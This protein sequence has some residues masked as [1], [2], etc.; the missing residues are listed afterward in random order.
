MATPK[1]APTSSQRPRRAVQRPVYLDD[2]VVDYAGKPSGQVVR[3]KEKAVMTSTPIS[4]Y[5]PFGTAGSSEDFMLQI[6][7]ITKQQSETARRQTELLE[8]VLLHSTPQVSTQSSRASSRHQSPRTQILQSVEKGQPKSEVSPRDVSS[9]P[10]PWSQPAKPPTPLV[11]ELSQALSKTQ[12]RDTLFQSPPPVSRQTTLSSHQ[13]ASPYCSTKSDPARNQL[14]DKAEPWMKSLPPLP[15]QSQSQPSKQPFH[16]IPPPKVYPT[17]SQFAEAEPMPQ[18]LHPAI[19]SQPRVDAESYTPHVSSYW[20]PTVEGPTF[21]DFV[22]ED[23][24]Q[25]VELRI[26]LDNLLHPQLPEHYKYSILLKHVKVPNGHRLVLAHAES[27]TPYT[28]ALQALDR[29][30]G[31]PYQFVLR[32]IEA[33]ENL[34]PIRAGDE[35]AFDDFS[36][37]VQAIVG[38]LKALKGDGIEELHSGSNVKRLLSRLPRSQQ[39]QFRRHHL[40]RNPDKTKFSLLEFADWLQLEAN[41]MEFD[42]TD[43]FRSTKRDQRAAFRDKVNQ[44]PYCMV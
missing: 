19:T 5:H 23:R 6:M 21:P 2:Y 41:C 12:I 37:R 43:E 11:E 29:R 7:E 4:T 32:E 44:P 14:P 42:P 36:L 10:H 38:M 13:Y 8:K 26:A 35:R 40:K 20:L 1:S 18:T 28:N 33:L 31:R 30:Y 27:V 16:Q 15:E 39:T 3:P 22:K 17:H 9:D 25:Y 24:A 34:P